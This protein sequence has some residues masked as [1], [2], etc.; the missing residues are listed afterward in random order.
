MDRAVAT[1]VPVEGFV[2]DG[3]PVAI[4]VEGDDRKAITVARLEAA[5]SNGV[6][7]CEM[8]KSDVS[9]KPKA[10]NPPRHRHGTVRNTT[11]R[12]RGRVRGADGELQEQ[13]AQRRRVTPGASATAAS[14]SSGPDS[15]PRFAGAV[16][17]ESEDVPPESSCSIDSAQQHEA[18][19]PQREAI[20]G[21]VK[22]RASPR[23]AL[24]R[25]MMLRHNIS[26]ACN[27]GRS[28]AYQGSG[29]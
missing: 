11:R 26:N 1:G 19:V 15:R 21:D 8:P 24:H 10:G 2:V 18:S 7:S 25:E 3:I 17:I 22:Q 28:N 20:H 27:Q 5:H 29:D 16:K 13:Q 6:F 14:N 23:E 4:P 9:L 12:T